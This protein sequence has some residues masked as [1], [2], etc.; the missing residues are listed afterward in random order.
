MKQKP[1]KSQTKTARELNSENFMLI[2]DSTEL[3]EIVAYVNIPQKY[4]ADIT[5]AIVSIT[6]GEY[7]QVWL[8]ESCAPYG[9][10]ANYHNPK[11]Y[12]AR[13][14]KYLNLEN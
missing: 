4:R 9:L 1:I 12:G 5:G 3:T 11:W 6:D 2:Q 10:Q 13:N 14:L 7:S 8:T